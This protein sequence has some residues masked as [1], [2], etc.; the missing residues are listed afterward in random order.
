MKQLL[1][2][3]CLALAVPGLAWADCYVEYKA[4]Q[5]D[6]LRLHY[7]ISRLAGATCPPRGEA[8]EALSGSLARDGWTLLG[9]VATSTEEPGQK[10][11]ADAGAYYLRY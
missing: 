9:V 3:L 1:F 5:D 10:K 11:R 2:T 4:K 7:G 6:P 8:A